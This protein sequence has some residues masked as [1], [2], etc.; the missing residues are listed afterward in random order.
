MA[1]SDPFWSPDGRFIGFYAQGKLKKIDPSGGPTQNI[2]T[3]DAYAGATW[4]RDG[5]IVLSPSN[6]KPL[7]R[8]SAMGGTPEPITSLDSARHQNSHRWP[9]F[10]PDSRHFLYTARSDVKENTGIYVGSLDS[11][12]TK[13]LL[14]AQSMR[15]MFVRDTCYLYARAP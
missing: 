1:G 15:Y 6:R 4:N 10:L 11:K 8:V 3:I 2:C 13:W 7:Y 9:H 5:T 14:P 12:E